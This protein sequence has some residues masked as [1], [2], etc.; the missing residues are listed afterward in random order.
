[1]PHKQRVV[2]GAVRCH[3][4]LL[5]RR[6]ETAPPGKELALGRDPLLELVPPPEDGFMRHFG[7]DLASVQRASDKETVR[8]VRKLGN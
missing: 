5:A 1:M 7:I 4:Q 3:L 8:M 6:F 2:L